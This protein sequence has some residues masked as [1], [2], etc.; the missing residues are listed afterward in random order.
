M[1][2]HK[3]SPACIVAFDAKCAVQN[4]LSSK[5]FLRVG[6]GATTPAGGVSTS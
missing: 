6:L 3:A 5:V 1:I 2:E 4:L